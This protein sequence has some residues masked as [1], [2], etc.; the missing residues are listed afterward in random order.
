MKKITYEEAL[1]KLEKITSQMEDSKTPLEEV[2]ALYKEAIELA[3]ICSEKLTT[4]E[5]EISLLKKD[6]EGLF[7]K[8]KFEL[9]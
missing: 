1:E 9:E 6:S 8:S 7:K 2:A 5:G 4:I 3:F